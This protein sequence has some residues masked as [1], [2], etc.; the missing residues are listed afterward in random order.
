MTHGLGQYHKLLLLCWATCVPVGTCNPMRNP[1]CLMANRLGVREQHL[2][3]CAENSRSKGNCT[4]K[5]SGLKKTLGKNICWSIK[6]KRDLTS[7]LPTPL[8]KTHIIMTHF[9]HPS[10]TINYCK[11][12]CCLK[13]P[14]QVLK[15]FSSIYC[16]VNLVLQ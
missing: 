3:S 9:C 2:P 12:L 6:K 11:V 10:A 4:G 1:T 5:R 16:L 13:H 14:H 7:V 15:C 8:Q